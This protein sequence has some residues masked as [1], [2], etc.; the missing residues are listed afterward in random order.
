MAT[1][2]FLAFACLAR[3]MQCKTVASGCN[4]GTSVFVEVLTTDLRPANNRNY[5]IRYNKNPGPG[6]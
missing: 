3:Q 6:T 4:S 5:G 2:A 1:N